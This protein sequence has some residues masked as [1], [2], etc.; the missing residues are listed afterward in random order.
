MPVDWCTFLQR[1]CNAMKGLHRTM[2][3]TKVTQGM[4]EDLLVWSQFLAEFSGIS[5]W[6]GEMDLKADFQVHSDVAG[7]LGFGIYFIGRWCAGTWPNEWHRNGIT[8]DL[9]FLDF[10]FQ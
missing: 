1:L 10:F 9:T 5:F 4:K 8:R 3:R 7:S 6:R 2:H